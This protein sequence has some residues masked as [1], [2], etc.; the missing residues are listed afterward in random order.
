MNKKLIILL[1][2]ISVALLL[3]IFVEWM[4][5]KYVQR[6]LLDSSVSVAKKM[7]PDEMPTLELTKQSEESYDQIVNRPLFIKG[8]KPVDEPK[9]ETAQVP[10]VPVVFDWELNG[11]F[12]KNKSLTALFSRAKTKVPKDNYRKIAV[13]A[14]LDGWK[15]TEIR[16]D[17]AILSQAGNKK[18]LLLR[19][20]KPKAP[21]PRNHAIPPVP[22]PG[23]VPNPESIPNPET[24]PVPET[25]EE[26]FEN[27]TDEQQI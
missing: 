20:S 16:E 22:Q 8:R 10:V 11:V 5:A 24:I 13:G 27:N 25:P 1:A 21:Q 19:K 3:I 18:E 12:T 7:P 2:S 23:T 6:E 15:L 9:P 17:R 14:D 4:Y 26:S